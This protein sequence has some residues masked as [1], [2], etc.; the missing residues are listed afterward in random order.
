MQPPIS[1]YNLSFN[2]SYDDSQQR[3]NIWMQ[4]VESVLDISY[5]YSHLN[6]IMMSRIQIQQIAA[7][8]ELPYMQRV[9]Q[10]KNAI[11][12]LA[13]VIAERL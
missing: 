5:Q 3:F 7:Q 6:E 11:L 1:N 2:Y 12:D 10:I 9:S 13:R 4:Y 8:D